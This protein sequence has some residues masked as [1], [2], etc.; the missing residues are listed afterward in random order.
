[1][2]RG[3]KLSR[4]LWVG[5]GAVA[6]AVL[7]F[8]FRQAP[9]SAIEDTLILQQAQSLGELHTARFSYQNVFE[10]ETSVEPARWV[11]YVPGG[12]SL[13]ESATRNDALVSAVGS[14]EAGVDLRSASVAHRGTSVVLTLPAPKLYEPTV[15]TWIRDVKGGLFWKDENLSSKASEAAKQRFREAAVRQGIYRKAFEEARNRVVELCRSMSGDKTDIIVE[16]SG[17]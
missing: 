2:L 14:V 11:S 6:L 13:V 15:R 3:V 7:P 16:Q 8:V 10:Y 12:A 1:M 4:V 5:A 17:A 9:G